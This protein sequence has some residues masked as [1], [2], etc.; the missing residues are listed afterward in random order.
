MLTFALAVRALA[1]GLCGPAA[2]G[3]TAP[4]SAESVV[5]DCNRA[6]IQELATLPGIGPARA[7]A[8][9]LHRVRHGPFRD[10]SELGAVDGIGPD[11]LAELAPHVRFGGVGETPAR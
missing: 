6:S 2:P 8:I 1:D 10:P 4:S 9:V 5:V 11:T 7:R 3:R